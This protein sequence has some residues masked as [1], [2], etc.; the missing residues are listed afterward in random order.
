MEVQVEVAH[1]KKD[2][3]A[4]LVATIVIHAIIIALLVWAVLP[5]SDPP[6]QELGGNG[7][8]IGLGGIEGEGAEGAP[9][10]GE[11]QPSDV[12]AQTATDDNSSQDDMISNTAEDDTKVVPPSNPA[13]TKKYT[14]SPVKDKKKQQPS[15]PI[16][17]NLKNLNALLGNGG[18][19]EGGGGSGNQ[20]GGPGGGKN[21]NGLGKEGNGKDASNG[22][23][24]KASPKRIL[25]S[26][27]EENYDCNGTS[28]QVV[29][30]EVNRSGKITKVTGNGAGTVNPDPCFRARAEKYVRE[31]YIYDSCNDCNAV[32]IDMVTVPFKLK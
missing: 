5:K 20:G 28:T 30:V 18:G 26:L 22:G 23:K 16:N 10:G 19:T 11:P 4:G 14:T 9:G 1:A 3:R 8:E 32:R 24:G 25:N 27:P 12:A 13:V 29:K 31:N 2:R 21:G 7:L 15:D 6:I 17:N